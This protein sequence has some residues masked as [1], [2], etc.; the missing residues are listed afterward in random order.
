[1][2]LKFISSGT[3]IWDSTHWTIFTYYCWSV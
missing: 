3:F 1:M 2:T